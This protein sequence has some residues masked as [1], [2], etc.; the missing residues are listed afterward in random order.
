MGN[1]TRRRFMQNGLL[2]GGALAMGDRACTAATPTIRR[3][4][5]SP[6]AYE[7]VRLLEGPMREQFDR[8]HAFFL[9]LSEDSLLKPFRQKAGLPAPGEDMGGWYTFYADFNPK[10]PFHGY[11]PGHSFGQYLSGLARAYA[12]TGSK[13]TQQKVHRL[14]EGFSK[15]ITPKFYVDYHLPAYTFDKTCCG[16][17]D[18]H[19]FAQDP[20]AMRA[21]GPATDAVIPFLPERALNRKEM[22]ARPHKD[23]A[24][25]WDESYTLPENLFLAYQRS[26]EVRYREMAKKY[27]E[28]E[29]WFTPLS[30]DQNVLPGEHAYSHLNSLC[31]AMQSYWNLDEERYL[32]AARNG[33]RMIQEQSFATGGW[34]P[35]ETFVKPGSSTLAESLTKTHSS[36]E[37]PCGAYG[38]FKITR[39]LLLETGDSRYGDSMERRALQHDPG[40]EAAATGRHELLLLGLQR[41]GAEGLLRRQVA[42]LFGDI[43]AG[44]GGLRHQRIHAE[45]PGCVREPVCAVRVA[46]AAG[47]SC[48]HTD[49]DNRISGFAREHD[50]VEAGSATDVR[51]DVAYSGMGRTEDAHCR[52]WQ[53]NRCGCEA[54]DVCACAADVEERRSHRARDRYAAATGDDSLSAGGR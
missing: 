42:V 41:Q 46:L 54:G 43:S 44:H 17:I 15:T 23:E 22:Y 35:N 19:Q 25:C 39:Y 31:S 8:N 33:F 45:R 14:V 3:T 6:V 37:T 5:L 21:L 11:I 2:A 24:Y 51:G 4:K 50:R 9:A 49:A 30:E 40:R 1:L 32:R 7:Q 34:G 38:H 53:G 29:S 27:I 16:L 20:V 26:G 36:F 48:V 12:Q 10:G 28:D 18:A 47:W 52:E 13:P